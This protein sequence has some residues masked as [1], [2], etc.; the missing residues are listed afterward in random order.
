MENLWPRAG[1]V[2]VYVSGKTA[3]L[4]VFVISFSHGEMGRSGS[5]AS[6]GGGSLLTGWVA[7]ALVDLNGAPDM[8]ALIENRV[9]RF[10]KKKERPG[11]A[12]ILGPL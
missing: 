12:G 2:K 10:G 9:K 11:F 5:M 6:P 4:S 3:N 8:E 1:G 7:W